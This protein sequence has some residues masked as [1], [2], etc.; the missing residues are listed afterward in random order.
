L[1]SL[2][3]EQA[4]QAIISLYPRTKIALVRGNRK[5]DVNGRFRGVV[6][7][8]QLC[9]H[10]RDQWCDIEHIVSVR[11]LALHDNQE[12]GHRKYSQTKEMTYLEQI[13]T[14]LRIA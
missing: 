12:R 1:T 11:T 4:V 8:D 10:R 13:G 2:S 9:F 6:T 3:S 7:L 14:F 5:M